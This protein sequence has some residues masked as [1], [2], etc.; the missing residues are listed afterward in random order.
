MLRAASLTERHPML[1]TEA[2][3]SVPDKTWSGGFG[4]PPSCLPV[5]S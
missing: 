5:A 1:R 2:S 3:R 4:W